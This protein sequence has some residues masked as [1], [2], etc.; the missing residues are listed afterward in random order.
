MRPSGCVAAPNEGMA[1]ALA[2]T[3]VHAHTLARTLTR[4]CTR[5]TACSAGVLPLVQLCTAPGDACCVLASAYGVFCNDKTWHAACHAN[6]GAAAAN[7]YVTSCTH[8]TGG[9]VV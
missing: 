4:V 2:C 5:S 6:D 1:C 7:N 9:A 8:T 3:L